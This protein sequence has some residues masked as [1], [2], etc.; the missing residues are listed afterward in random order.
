MLIE[1]GRRGWTTLRSGCVA[2]RGGGGWRASRRCDRPR[3]GR[4]RQ[5]VAKWAAAMTRTIR[6]GRRAGSRAPKR[7]R[8]AT[9]AEVEAQVLEVR[10][11]AGGQPVGAGRRAGGRVGAGEAR[12]GR[13]AVAHDRADPGRAGATG[14]AGPGAAL[15]GDPV[16]G[17][18]RQRGRATWPR[19]TWSARAT[20][21]AACASTR[22]TRSTSPPTG[23]HRDRRRPRRR[24]R[25]SARCTRCG[26]ATGCRRRVQF[27]NGGPFVVA[28]R[29]RR[30]RPGLPAPGRHAGV[31]PA[32]RAVAQRHDRALQ[33][34][35]RQALLPPG[36]LRRT[37]PA[38]RAGRRV[39]AFH[40]ASTAIA[41]PAPRPGRDAPGPRRA[42][43]AGR[44]GPRRL[45]GRR[46][47][48]V[49]PLHPLRP[50]AAPLGRAIAM[51]DATP[52]S[53]SPPPWTSPSSPAR[54]PA[55]LRRARRADHHQPPRRP[56]RSTPARRDA[57]CACRSASPTGSAT[58]QAR[59]QLTTGKRC[60][61]GTR[62]ESPV[63]D[64]V[65][66]VRCRR[67]CTPRRCA[68]SWC[69]GRSCGRRLVPWRSPSI[70]SSWGP[71]V[72][73]A[74]RSS[75][76]SRPVDCGCGR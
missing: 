64:A 52:T 7:W 2:R 36:A 8:T 56:R 51:P 72:A 44:R 67:P 16:P 5:W 70:M 11:R 43:A 39:R 31:H 1:R 15:E 10:A 28:D 41:P 38:R 71:R 68:P 57:P 25:R 34:H 19:S 63:N 49:H 32:Q 58:R 45:A 55:G 46:P 12:R 65:A 53:T 27:D 26:H 21:T 75:A 33:R 24:A 62:T 54:Q 35:L 76:T 50:K 40:N 23:R 69:A 59:A 13:A 37:R 9:A 20:W 6:R 42:T 47:D 74:P 66:A 14:R 73:L 30:G 60:A 29:R 22:S 4:T 18:G 48:R 61:G 3:A 17:A